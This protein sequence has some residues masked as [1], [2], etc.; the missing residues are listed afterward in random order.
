MR[1]GKLVHVV[2]DDDGVRK[3]VGFLLRTA[4]FAVRPWAAGG[5]L[6]RAVDASQPACI[7]LDLQMPPPDGLTVQREL[8][9]RGI[10]IPVVIFTGRGDPGVAV[11]ALR[12][13]AH[14]VIEKPFER[15]HLLGV[16][17]GVFRLMGDPGEA[18]RRAAAAKR[19][20]STLQDGEYAVLRYLAE[21]LTNAQIADALD[22]PAP[23][24]EL[25]R[26]SLLRKLDVPHLSA[27]LRLFFATG[28]SAGDQYG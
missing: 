25:R 2:D 13:G 16:I 26:A 22:V 14:D 11:Q 7:L 1:R 23:A 15:A 21:G 17:D 27:A 3:A 20:L 12:A 19:A 8:I 4:G 6:L 24:V 18:G 9:A 5:D 28:A 10:T